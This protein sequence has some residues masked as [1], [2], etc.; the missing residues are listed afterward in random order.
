MQN[1]LNLSWHVG[2]YRDTVGLVHAKLHRCSKLTS[3][4]INPYSDVI[5]VFGQVCHLIITMYWSQKKLL[6]SDHR[7]LYILSIHFVFSQLFNKY[8][9]NMS[10]QET[11]KN[12]KQTAPNSQRSFK[13]RLYKSVRTVQ[14]TCI[15]LFLILVLNFNN[16]N[17]TAFNVRVY[18]KKVIFR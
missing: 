16:S 3:D 9:W 1:A 5:N 13:S 12:C 2:L 6:C 11:N 4:F 18:G 17:N 14:K 15:K 8:L 10:I 7:K